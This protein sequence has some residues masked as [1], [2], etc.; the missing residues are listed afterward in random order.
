MK[1]FSHQEKDEF[2]PRK[3]N[4]TPRKYISIASPHLGV[5]RPQNRYTHIHIHICILCIIY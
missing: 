5:R 2:S 1:C 4:I 3:V